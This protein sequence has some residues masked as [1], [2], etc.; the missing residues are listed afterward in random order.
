[1]RIQTSAH[2]E[3]QDRALRLL[4]EDLAASH[5][6]GVALAADVTRAKQRADAAEARADRAEH[7]AKTAR[8][9][10]TGGHAR[11][12]AENQQ[13]RIANRALH[14]QVANAM[15]YGPAELAVIDAGGEQAL[16]AAEREAR[17]AAVLAE[18]STT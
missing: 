15:G 6:N 1:M 13:L 17:A 8:E 3:A 10:L 16:A 18:T 5:A 2:V 12:F 4:R 9:A 11:L 7:E 14:Q